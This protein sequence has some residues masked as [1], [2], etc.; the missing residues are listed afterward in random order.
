MTSKDM[1]LTGRERTFGEDELIVSKTD[2][3]GRIT[4]AND[5][6]LKVSGYREA[7][8]LGQPHSIIRHPAMPRC[9]FRFLWEQIATGKECFAYVNNR[10][11]DGDNYWVFAHVTPNFDRSGAIIG[12][13]SNRR[14]PRRPAVEAIA[15]IYASLLEVES[16]AP[17]RKT[18]V[19]ASFAALQRFIA[20]KGKSYDELILSL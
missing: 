5:V 14:V 13:H 8:L 17:D 3:Q 1:F 9:V 2:P 12:Y 18:G 7:E 6:F 15:P 10:A 19:E 20:D 11:K 16:R 4:Y